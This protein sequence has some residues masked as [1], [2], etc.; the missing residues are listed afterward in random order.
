MSTTHAGTSRTARLTLLAGVAAA[1]IGAAPSTG[2]AAAGA[3]VEVD[4]N[5]LSHI[6]GPDEDNR[7]RFYRS[8]TKIMVIDAVR[9]TAGDGCDRINDYRVSCDSTGVG[10][11]VALLGNRSD[12][13]AI[14][15]PLPAYVEGGSGND[16]YY[17][18]TA[19]SESRVFYMGQ[20]DQDWVS[21]A[22]TSQPSRVTLDHLAN[23]GRIGLDSDNIQPD[24]E[25]A[26]VSSTST[27]GL[28]PPAPAPAG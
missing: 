2:H 10:A 5:T 28:I 7:V 9:I 12:S 13:V 1:A 18:G 22:L 20:G 21:Y 17:G 15:V 27:A 26:V 19:P 25:H 23:D 6:A 3:L 24:V 11:I 16:A 14:D 8:G 4:R